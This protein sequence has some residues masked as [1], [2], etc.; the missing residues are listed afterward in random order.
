[1]PTI[2]FLHTALVHVATFDHLLAAADPGA[3]SVHAVVPDL[4]AAARVDGPN[5][6]AEGVRAE[7][8]RLVQQGA[9]VV[10]C[11]CSTLG[12]L[13]EAL[14]SGLGV[15]LVR[16]DRPMA[17]EAVARGGRIAVVAALESTLGPTREL[18]GEEARR[19]GVRPEVREVCVQEAWA[20]FEAGDTAGYLAQVAAAARSLADA[21]DVVVLAQASM[22][23]ARTLLD[24]LAVPVL[25]SPGLA[26]EA[27]L[28]A[29]ARR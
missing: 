15:P 26:V 21:G 9:D 1:M 28:A 12:P 18:L 25:V 19:A 2:G 27:A 6:V 29:A 24:D 20:A 4:L 22:A 16:V 3:A 11:T 10:V 8:A 5:A 14:A 23:G 13:T 17:R 7:L